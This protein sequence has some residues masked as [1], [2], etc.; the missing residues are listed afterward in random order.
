[1]DL[2]PPLRVCRLRAC[3]VRLDRTGL[4]EQLF[5]GLCLTQAEG[6]EGYGCGVSQWGRGQCDVALA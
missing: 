4:K 6:R 1:M 2:D 5:W 3:V